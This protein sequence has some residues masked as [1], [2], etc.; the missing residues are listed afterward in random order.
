MA[1]SQG[2]DASF[3][4]LRA[5]YDAIHIRLSPSHEERLIIQM[6]RNLRAVGRYRAAELVL[7]YRASGEEIS[8]RPYLLHAMQDG[9]RVAMPHLVKSDIVFELLADDERALDTGA[10][11]EE[12]SLD[13]FDLAESICLVPGL[14]FDA[15]GYRVSYGAGFLD[16]FLREF[17]GLKVGLARGFNISSNPLPHAI[18][19]VPVDILVSENAVWSCRR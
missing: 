3:N 8:A 9:K 11:D 4:A 7:G 17:P 12:L 2:Q 19:D 13:D 1:S 16:N 15:E 14:V 10:V 5:A 18:C 6:E